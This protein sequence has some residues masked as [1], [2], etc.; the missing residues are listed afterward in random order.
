MLVGQRIRQLREE[1]GLSQADLQEASGLQ[2]SYISR[3]E[4]GHIVPSLET[5]QKFSAGLDV[6][7]YRLFYE[8]EEPPP[9]PHLTPRRTL[10]E[11]AEE[12]ATGGLRAKFL[13]KFWTLL[14]SRMTKSDRMFLLKLAKKLAIR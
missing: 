1:K 14:L 2:T 4:R 13:L 12:L 10:E 7:L 9:T 8:G 5:L 11:L 6:P 3:V